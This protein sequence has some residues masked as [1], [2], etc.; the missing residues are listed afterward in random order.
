MRHIRVKWFY[1]AQLALSIIVHMEAFSPAEGL[2]RPR[3]DF[4]FQYYPWFYHWTGHK[5]GG[6][7]L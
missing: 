6:V 1:Q 5:S 3:L 2:L 4:D 7:R